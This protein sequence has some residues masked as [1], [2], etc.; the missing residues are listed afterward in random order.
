MPIILQVKY[1]DNSEEVIRISAQI[2]RKNTE[3]VSK[4][5]ITDKEVSS[6]VL[7]PYWET[8]DVDV[9]NNYWP[10]RVVESRLELFKK[11]KKSLMQKYN[12]KLKSDDENEDKDENVSEDKGENLGDDKGDSKGNT[13]TKQRQAA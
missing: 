9:N 11:K 2:W 8:A 3:K 10:A 6:I 12:E 13:K 4:M 5:L 7:D 1:K